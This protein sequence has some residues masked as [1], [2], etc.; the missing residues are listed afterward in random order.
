V[1]S[2]TALLKE[3]AGSTAVARLFVLSGRPDALAAVV[4]S[5]DAGDNSRRSAAL[6]AAGDSG[7][8]ATLPL[9][10]KGLA[11]TD[12][13]VRADAVL[14]LG[15][16]APGEA[17]ARIVPLLAQT[18]DVSA[19]VKNALARLPSGKADEAMRAA[20][21]DASSSA[22]ARAT[23]L[24][25]LV[26]RLDK[27]TFP[28]ALR[29]TKESD[30]SVRTA[31]FAALGAL[32]GPR[33]LPAVLGAASAI[34]KSADRRAWTKAVFAA[35]ESAPDRAAAVNLLAASA[36]APDFAEKSTLLEALAAMPGDE[37]KNS[38]RTMLA[39]KEIETRKEVIRALASAR[40]ATAR[41]LLAESALKA[42]DESERTLALRGF[43]DTLAAL[44]PKA[45][46]R[47]AEYRRVWPVAGGEEKSAMLSAA[48]DIKDAAA[49]RF[50]EEFTPPPA[51]AAP[52]SPTSNHAKNAPAV[53]TAGV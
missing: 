35:A 24:G 45:A 3:L 23:L 16:A 21:A 26:A 4:E 10:D 49:Q 31:A 48:K 46:D 17:A 1:K 47:I 22:V 43:L 15:R 37:A 42:T 41:T 28:L 12:A 34:V 8:A 32:A 40:N 19:A 25:A 20:L 27:E 5:W 13:L 6:A 30:A 33:D 11:S 38:L 51:P 14:A 39:S 36:V 52:S 18:P 9:I 44:N 53:V 29:L 7:S 2:E 50:V